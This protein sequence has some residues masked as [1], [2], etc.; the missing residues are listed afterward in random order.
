MKALFEFSFNVDR[1]IWILILIIAL[2]I[3]RNHY[4]ISIA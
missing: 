3:E 4:L 1:C 2:G